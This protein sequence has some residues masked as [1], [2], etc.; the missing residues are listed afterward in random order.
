[1]AFGGESW[2]RCFMCS[3]SPWFS[4]HFQFHPMTLKGL[5]WTWLL[6]N[7]TVFNHHKIRTEA[8]MTWSEPQVVL[9][10]QCFK[11]TCILLLLLKRHI[12]QHMHCL[13]GKVCSGKK[14][15]KLNCSVLWKDRFLLS[16]CVPQNWRGTKQRHAQKDIGFPIVEFNMCNCLAMGYFVSRRHMCG[17]SFS[18]KCC[19]LFQ[20]ELLG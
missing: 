4:K 13:H 2:K 18:A 6:I 17:F 5:V 9:T 12:V 8:R 15:A 3:E 1:M 7:N 11:G 19:L 10:G 20:F 16:T 14:K